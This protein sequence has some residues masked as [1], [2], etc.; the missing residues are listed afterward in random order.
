M[1]SDLLLYEIFHQENLFYTKLLYLIN[2]V[3]FNLEIN[4]TSN[5]I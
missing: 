1:Q 2:A 3:F 5:F 4:S